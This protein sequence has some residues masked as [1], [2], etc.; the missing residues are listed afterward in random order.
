MGSLMIVREPL[1]YWEREDARE[2]VRDW[3][4][5]LETAARR[6]EPLGGPLLHEYARRVSRLRAAEARMPHV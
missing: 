5:R 3:L 1:A 2:A 4:L 6:R